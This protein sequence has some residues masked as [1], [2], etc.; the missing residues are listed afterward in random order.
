[1]IRVTAIGSS[2]RRKKYKEKSD[3]TGERRGQRRGGRDMELR[4]TR[5]SGG[6]GAA[7]P[8]LCVPPHTR[9][10]PLP[11]PRLARALLFLEC[12]LR[13]EAEENR[14]RRRRRARPTLSPPPSIHVCAPLWFAALCFRFSRRCESGY[15]PGQIRPRRYQPPPAWAHT[16]TRPLS[17]LRTLGRRDLDQVQA[18]QPSTGNGTLKK[19]TQT[20]QEDTSTRKR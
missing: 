20:P 4:S 14:G 10:P 6:G 5:A 12:A 11:S 15:D 9:P 16:H 3:E 8:P 17:P 1:M 18:Q 2:Q 7:E 19:H 13:Q